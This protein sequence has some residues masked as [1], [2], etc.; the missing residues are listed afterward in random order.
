MSVMISTHKSGSLALGDFGEYSS[1]HLELFSGLF[2]L[3]DSFLC[4][5]LSFSGGSSICIKFRR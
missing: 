2:D 5:F 1:E 4:E 3:I